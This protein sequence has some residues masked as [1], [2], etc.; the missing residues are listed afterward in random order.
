MGARSLRITLSAAPNVD[1]GTTAKMQG[2]WLL[3]FFSTL[4]TVGAILLW[5]ATALNPH[6]DVT[7]AYTGFFAVLTSVAALLGWV[8]LA[9]L[10]FNGRR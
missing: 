10:L 9:Y 4:S 2:R 5:R 3:A 8:I 7:L 1:G 6:N